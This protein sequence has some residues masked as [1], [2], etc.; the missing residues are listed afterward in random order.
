LAAAGAAQFASTTK[1]RIIPVYISKIA[2]PPIR[3]YRE[4]FL[5]SVSVA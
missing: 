4:N 1:T 2:V 5:L 3:A